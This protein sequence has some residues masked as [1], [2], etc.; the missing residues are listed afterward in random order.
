MR[1]PLLRVMGRVC[2]GVRFEGRVGEDWER[3]AWR[4]A[5]GG[6]QRHAGGGDGGGWLDCHGS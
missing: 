4:R 3:Y 1:E 2:V 6:D 5:G